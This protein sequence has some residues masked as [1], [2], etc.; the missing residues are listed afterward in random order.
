MGWWRHKSKVSQQSA[1]KLEFH[2]IH[3]YIQN[4]YRLTIRRNVQLFFIWF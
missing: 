3:S 4:K 1:E 2:V